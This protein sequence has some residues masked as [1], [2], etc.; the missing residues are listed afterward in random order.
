MLWHAFALLSH[1][2]DR[3][4]L[5]FERIHG[6]PRLCR[7]PDD[8]I[9]IFD[10]ADEAIWSAN[11]LSVCA[12]SGLIGLLAEPRSLA[13]IALRLSMPPPLASPQALRTVTFLPLLETL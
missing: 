2:G 10:Q 11:A 1:G 9:R 5:R 6:R 4:G 13:D 3:I 8:V 7:H 12:E